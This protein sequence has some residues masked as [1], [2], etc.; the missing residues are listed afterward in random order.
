MLQP[1]Y[2]DNGAMYGC[3]SRVATCFKELTHT[4][5]MFGYDPEVSKS[6][7]IC[8]LA[9]QPRLKAMFLAMDP[10]ITWKRV[11]RHVGGHIASTAMCP[12][13]I[14]LKVAD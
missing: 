6:I 13:F 10:H 14:E 11:S 4:G 2:A 5:P 12:R 9:D 1:W 3:G 7:S 8:T